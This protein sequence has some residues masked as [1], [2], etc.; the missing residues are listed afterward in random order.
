MTIIRTTKIRGRNTS[1]MVEPQPQVKNFWGLVQS[2][3]TPWRN[4]PTVVDWDRDGGMATFDHANG[5]K[6]FIE[7]I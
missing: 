6:T 7:Y 2:T 3:E 4:D 5:D 1:V